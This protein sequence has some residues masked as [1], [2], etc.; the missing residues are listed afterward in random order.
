MIVNKY[1]A[2]HA[3]KIKDQTAAVILHSTLY[4]FDSSLNYRVISVLDP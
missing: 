2:I 3:I 1:D 4:F